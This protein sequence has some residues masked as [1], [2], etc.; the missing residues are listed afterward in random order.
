MPA[1]RAVDVRPAHCPG[2]AT[3]VAAVH[4]AVAV[5]PWAAGCAPW[6][7][8]PLSAVA[9]LAWRAARR[10]VP[11]RGAGIRRLRNAGPIWLATLADGTERPAELLDGS[12]VLARFV[13]CQMRVAGQKLDWWLPA[14]AVPATGFRRLKVALRC[15][16]QA[17]G[18]AL[19]DSDQ[20]NHEEAARRA[21]GSRQAN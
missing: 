17:A 2:L 15:G 7:A 4:A 18:P 11:G 14:Y 9:C 21:P 3:L 16:Q 8:L 13:F 5:A 10:A 19:L 20:S 6:I 1:A 12:R